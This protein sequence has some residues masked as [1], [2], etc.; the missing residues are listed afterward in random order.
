MNIKLY[1]IKWA[2]TVFVNSFYSKDNNAIFKAS[3]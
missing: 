1:F 2:A 3:L